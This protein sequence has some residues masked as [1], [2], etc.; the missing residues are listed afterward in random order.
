MDS[1]LDSLF[2]M[3]GCILAGTPC[4]HIR[5]TVPES[6][7]GD[8]SEPLGAADHR[9]VAE[10][11][12]AIPEPSECREQAVSNQHRCTQSEE[13]QTAD[14]A[15]E[16]YSEEEDDEETLR[17]LFDQVDFDKNGC[18]SQDELSHALDQY[19]TAQKKELVEAFETLMKKHFGT[20]N[21]KD[22]S[23]PA[24]ISFEEYK[25]IFNDLPRVHGQRAHW[26]SSLRLDLELARYLKVGDPFDGLQGLRDIGTEMVDDYVR[27]LCDKFSKALPRIIKKGISQLSHTGAVVEKYHNSKYSMDSSAYIGDF[28]SL[29]HFYDGPDNLIGYPNPEVEKGCHLEHCNRKNAYVTFT[30]SNYGIT[31][32]PALEWE[33][34]ASPQEGVVYPH[35]PC[36]PKLWDAPRKGWHPPLLFRSNMQ[37]GGWHPP[38]VTWRGE[39]GRQPRPLEDF[40]HLDIANRAG[41]QRAEVIG[42]RL[43]S[44]PMFV[45]YNA[46]LRRFPVHNYRALEGNNYETTIF[47][48]ISA[49]MKLSKE[50]K[51]PHSRKLYR[52]LGGMLLPDVFWRAK[53]GFRGAV[54]WGLMSTTCDREVAMQYSGV[55]RNKGSV[56]EITAGRI[57]IGADLS[58]VSQYPG[59]GEYLFPPL[60]CL[61][62]VNEPRV[63]REVVVFPLRVNVCLKG[64][65]LEQVIERRMRLHLAMVKNL[66]EDLDFEAAARITCFQVT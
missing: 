15:F 44:G 20:Q 30:S 54:E 17:A 41:L 49:I 5:S 34:V 43:Y 27:D 21:E 18:I 61:E 9:C 47:C 63:E 56:F 12:F 45:L 4:T 23:F 35:T 66:R 37:I 6:M 42:V 22:Q 59:E 11:I 62:V 60:S 7:E 10:I 3:R 36:D 29:E 55:D 52:G 38:L 32:Y 8:N 31:T 57:D 1:S 50:T 2:T 24:E 25:S 53:D 19:R 65:T 33:F 13:Q 14:D 51:I 39:H 16:P 64:S 48:I 28:A 26:A 46:S 40:L 58:W